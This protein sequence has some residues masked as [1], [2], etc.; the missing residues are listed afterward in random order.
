[1]SEFLSLSNGYLQNILEQPAAIR[2]TIAGLTGLTAFRPFSEQLAAGQ[3]WRVVLT[4]MGASYA[5]LHPLYLQLVAHGMDAHRIETSEL[6][7]HAP[8]L[9]APQTLIIA[10][11]QSGASGETV[12]LLERVRKERVRNNQIPL[13]GVTNT[14]DSPLAA[15]SDAIVLTQ[16]GAEYSVSSKTY[17]ATLAALELLGTTLCAQDPTHARAQ[18]EQTAK[19]MEQYLEH[20]QEDVATLVKELAGIQHM[21]LVGRGPSLAAV[22]AGALIIKEASHFPCQGMSSAAFRHGPME[23][24]TPELFVLVFRGVAPT[25]E[26]NL[27][28]AAD[29][30]AAGGRVAVVS[31]S[32]SAN[33]FSFPQVAPTTLPLLEFLVPEMLSLALAQL[34][35]H[36][37]GVFT[38]T[39]KVTTEE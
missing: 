18:L 15:A 20:W 33:V 36:N 10:V 22:E 1:M 11:S 16:A 37:P 31:E 7:Y 25:I 6:L 32:A 17:V 8:Q 3:L 26:H 24:I 9:L 28:L 35:G 29:I 2:A 30:R 5:A 23:M 34:R 39:S 14:P 13:I 38:R 12:T 27:R 21:V 4:G 19:G